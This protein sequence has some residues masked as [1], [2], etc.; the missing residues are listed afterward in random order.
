MTQHGDTHNSRPASQAPARQAAATMLIA[1]AVLA[2]LLALTG[3]K[4]ATPAAKPKPR[5]VAVQVI[6]P[7][8]ALAD[9][10]KVLSYT[11]PSRTVRVVAEVAGR[12]EKLAVT[13]G[14]TVIGNGGEKSLIVRLNTDLLQATLDLCLA[15]TDFTKLE[16]DQLK[17][18]V[19]RGAASQQ[20]WDRA[21][22]QYLM[23]KARMDSA[24]AQLDRT[25]I[26]A[27]ISGVLN[28][29]PVELGEYLQPGDLIAEIVDVDSV[30]V[31]VSVPELD[32]SYL[33]VG[34]EAHV[35]ARVR[36][37]QE[38]FQ[39]EITYMSKLAD[40]GTFTTRVEVT[41][42]NADGRLLTGKMVDVVLTRQI[43]ND[44]IMIPLDAVI[45][46]QHDQVVYVVSP[47]VELAFD[48]PAS[49]IGS[50]EEGDDVDWRRMTIK[51][52]GGTATIY[53]SDS[54]EP[55]EPAQA[56][57]EHHYPRGKVTKIQRADGQDTVRLHVRF[58][59][60]PST[61][62]LRFGAERSGETA[63]T[64][65]APWEPGTVIAFDL[66]GQSETE[67]DIGPVEAHRDYPDNIQPDQ[68]FAEVKH[69]A[70]RREVTLGIF[71]GSDVQI[72][73][74]LAARDML[75][76]EG[77]Q[78]VGPGQVVRIVP[79]VK[80][81]TAQAAQTDPADPSDTPTEEQP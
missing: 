5:N 46:R 14:Q 2:S 79:S 18:M 39:G 55:D 48:V 36:G 24:Q 10:F 71:R 12:I 68:I 32:V 66:P 49:A 11:E 41:I 8:P 59:G 16:A 61:V 63:P 64:P 22:A 60:P 65:F 38:K 9:T 52:G 75:I 72:L 42:D 31:V 58:E 3:C 21:N 50:L 54:G 53:G 51:M 76:V 33:S 20:E 80:Q 45:R 6:Q 56:M 69:F 81:L 7:I 29:L 62:I 19:D 15:D 34:D 70:E 74:G 30:K 17:E 27:P 78:Y 28:S 57:T 77:Q 40:P 4:K 67:V 35:T 44:A 1:L 13:E 73:T 47:A 23:A 43:I 37:R 25:V 26:Y